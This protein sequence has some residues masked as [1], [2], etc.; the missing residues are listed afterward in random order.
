MHRLVVFIE[1]SGGKEICS[2]R[3]FH[4]LLVSYRAALTSMSSTERVSTNACTA[5]CRATAYMIVPAVDSETSSKPYRLP[6]VMYVCEAPP[7]RGRSLGGRTPIEH[8]CQHVEVDGAG[9]VPASGSP[10]R[11]VKTMPRTRTGAPPDRYGTKSAPASIDP[12]CL[13]CQESS[14]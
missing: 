10:M 2:P 1:N 14:P 9:L 5:R 3:C 7:T 6:C 13:S 12:A 4:A 11:I 8:N